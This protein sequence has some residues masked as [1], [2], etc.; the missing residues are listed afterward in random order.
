MSFSFALRRETF[1]GR[2]FRPKGSGRSAS[3]SVVDMVKRLSS[4]C[5]RTNTKVIKVIVEQNTSSVRPLRSTGITRCLHYYGP[6]RLPHRPGCGYGFPQPVGLG[7]TGEDLSGSS[8]DLSVPAVS[9][10][11]GKFTRPCR[12]VMAT[13]PLPVWRCWLHHLWQAGHFHKRNEAESSS[14]FRITAGTFVPSG[15]ARPVTR[16]HAEFPSWSTNS[17]HGQYLSTDKINQTS[18]DAPEAQSF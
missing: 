14:R 1:G 6:R 9:N 4:S 11:P 8:V 10:H 16:P 12:F 5:S 13:F 7:S 17:Y 18:P 3:C 15:S 2:W